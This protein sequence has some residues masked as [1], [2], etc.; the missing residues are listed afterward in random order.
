MK[1]YIMKEYRVYS[2]LH[3]GAPH[4]F[5]GIIFEQ[6]YDDAVNDNVILTGDI[7]DIANCKKSEIKLWRSR[8]DDL[9]EDY[10]ERFLLGNHCC[11]KP[12]NYYLKID[13]VV[14]CHG[15]TLFWNMEQIIEWENKTGGKGLFSRTAYSMYKNSVEFFTDYEGYYEPPI[16]V[17]DKAVEICEHYKADTLVCG[18]RHKMADLQYK[19]I[20]FVTVTRGVT[21]LT[22]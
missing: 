9:M 4:Q 21:T 22:L 14:F 3:L 7:I 1:E 10:E 13:N 6:V 12:I 18:H 5:N 8:I 2:D 11:K 20:R 19:G 15:H 17:L 16:Y